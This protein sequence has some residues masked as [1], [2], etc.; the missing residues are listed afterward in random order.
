MKYEIRL[1]VDG[2]YNKS[3]QQVGGGILVQ[4]LD[5]DGKH[6]VPEQEERVAAPDTPGMHN[7]TGELL[8]VTKGLTM[9]KNL[10]EETGIEAEKIVVY[11]DYDGIRNWPLDAW[12]VKKK[13]TSDYREYVQLLMRTM[14][15][16]FH[17]VKAH[18][19]VRENEIVDTLAKMACGNEVR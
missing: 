1:W 17:K 3:T 8:A 15:I 14:P 19:G 7:I 18:S 9:I 5:K 6:L 16:M 2:S 10:I 12:K 13:A 11:Y 4:I